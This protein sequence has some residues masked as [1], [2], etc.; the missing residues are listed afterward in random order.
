MND[1]PREHG[2]LFSPAMAR[3]IHDGR[4]T[5]T[6]RVITERNSVCDIAFTQVA[7][8]FI[9]GPPSIFCAESRDKITVWPVDSIY[10]PGHSIVARETWRTLSA[11]DHVK[12]SNIAPGAP[13]Q[14]ECGGT[15]LP[16]WDRLACPGKL[17]PS[18]FMPRRFA[19]SVRRIVSVRPE[20]LQDITEAD[21]IAEGMTVWAG[22][23]GV[24]YYG[25]VRADV[26]ETDPRQ[27]YARL[28]DSLNAKRGF[29]WASNPWVWRIE[30]EKENVSRATN[31]RSSYARAK[32]R[33]AAQQM[34]I[35][36]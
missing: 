9:G 23:H 16:G 11:L 14:Y 3:A 18:L 5:V 10:K 2:M 27:T 35:V 36:A 1:K 6:R 12:P 29:D 26:W 20:R 22:L 17:R 24:K 7:L 31:P 8:R 28:W 15:S 34:E 32:Q 33:R 30:F 19:R 13:I 21:A 25:I 4:K